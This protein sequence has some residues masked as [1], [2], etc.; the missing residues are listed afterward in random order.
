MEVQCTAEYSILLHLQRGIVV[1]FRGAFRA[2]C[3]TLLLTPR[4]ASHHVRETRTR[5][6][7]TT[8]HVYYE[9]TEL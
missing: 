4:Q 6:H 5:R 8:V 3:V 2:G 1:W 7:V 9:R